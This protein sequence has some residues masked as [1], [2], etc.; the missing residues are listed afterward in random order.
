MSPKLAALIAEQGGLVT[1]AQALRWASRR[2]VD[3]WIANGAWVLVRRGVYATRERYVAARTSSQRHLL[4]SV[5]RCLVTG[6]DT[7]VSH[8][9]AATVLY[10][11]LLRA[12][13]GQP[14]VTVH[15][16]DSTTAGGVLG[17]YLAPVPAEH[18]MLVAG[19]PLTS[20][21]RTV[22]DLCRTPDERAAAVVADGGLR[23][24]V[25][26]EA[27]LNVLAYCRRWP[28]VAAA[29]E[30]V[31]LASR[32][33]E[34]PLE[35]LALRWCRLQGLPVPE[36]QLTVRTE[37]GRFLARVDFVWPELRTVAE[38]DGQL[39][40]DEDEA[41]RQRPRRVAWREK[42]REDGMRDH[43]LEVARGYWSDDADDG[44][45]FAQRV[46]RAMARA[47]SYTGTPTYRILDERDHAQR[48]PLAA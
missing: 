7:V 18:R 47:A 2:D 4:M 23:L 42:L 21:A 48:G 46:R 30:T 15:T 34:T 12:L 5:A 11:P 28:Y 41:D 8:E 25:P 1:R 10:I 32:W 43:G 24:G 19:V 27:I 33:S 13:T 45:Q 16:P 29:R 39:K 6:G 22:A 9:S 31:R 20:P 26:R 40:Y 35:S 36:Q 17:R 3:R 44:A 14:R 38:V 37:Q